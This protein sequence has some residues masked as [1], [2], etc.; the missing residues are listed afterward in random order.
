MTQ[1]WKEAGFPDGV[2]NMIC[3]PGSQ[4]GAPILDH[5]DLGGVHFTGSTQVFSTIW[6][7]IGSDI[8]KYRVYPRIVGETGGKDFIFVHA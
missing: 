7:A 3:G 2:I 8:R 4:L 5:V 1:I 6:R